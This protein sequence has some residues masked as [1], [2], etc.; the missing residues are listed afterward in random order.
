MS[1]PSDVLFMFSFLGISKSN[2]C[3]GHSSMNS[4]IAHGG[5]AATQHGSPRILEV[6]EWKMGLAKCPDPRIAVALDHPLK[7]ASDLMQV[8]RSLLMLLTF[9]EKIRFQMTTAVW[10]SIY[11]RLGCLTVPA[12]TLSACFTSL[13]TPFAIQTSEVHGL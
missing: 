8:T 10:V 2:L 13:P 3:Y 4:L 11:Y 9:M 6:V 7:T 1:S 5:K 12:G